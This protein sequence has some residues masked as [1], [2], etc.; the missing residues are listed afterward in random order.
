[1]QLSL[2]KAHSTTVL[3]SDDGIFGSPSHIGCAK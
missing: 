3:G 2:E 1:L